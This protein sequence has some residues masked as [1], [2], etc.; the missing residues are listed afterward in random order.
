MSILLGS[1]PRPYESS[2]Q[3]HH[4]LRPQIT[5]IHLPLRSCLLPEEEILRC[6]G[7]VRFCSRSSSSMFYRTHSEHAIRPRQRLHYSSPSLF[8]PSSS[9]IQHQLHQIISMTRYV[10]RM[11]L[12]FLRYIDY[13]KEHPSR[14]RRNSS[15]FSPERS[16]STSTTRTRRMRR[17]D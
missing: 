3:E 11:N 15:Y 2:Q 17:R 10:R 4:R 14:R 12:M 9:C 8:F 6:S 16:F 5:N 13:A 1:S 7:C